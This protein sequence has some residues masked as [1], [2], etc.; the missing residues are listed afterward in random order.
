V[1]IN[2]LISLLFSAALL[3]SQQAT[4]ESFLARASDLEKHEDF[5]GAEKVYAEAVAGFPGQSEVLKRLG[6]VYQTELKFPESIEVLQKVLAANSQYPEANFYLGLSYFGLNDFEKALTGFNA[7]LK[8]NPKYRRARYY[9]A[10]ALQALDRKLEAVQYLDELVRDDPGDIKV[11]YQLARLYRSMA[12]HALKQIADV[13]ADSVLIHALKAESYSEDE[14]YADALKEYKE[15]VKKDSNFPGVHFG[16]GEVYH[17][18][19]D[20]VLSEVELK[21]ALRE[22]P[23]H[24]AAN[25]YLADIL[26]KEQK[27]S[28]A[29]PLFQRA[30]AGDPKMVLAQFQLGKCY[31]VLGDTEH[32]LLAFLKTAELN[33][34][35]KEAHY[36][37]AQIYAQRK[38]DTQRNYHMAI[39]EKLSKEEKDKSLKITER[40]LE[41]ERR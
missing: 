7:E 28:E 29:L 21:E 32:A 26:L 41:E 25:Y 24:P 30:V 19:S 13:D 4:L 6:I 1:L 12:L 36:R 39:F 10:M 38:D 22:D 14:K 5:A 31:L 16:L 40:A 23:N 18:T 35:F 17:R 2:L 34:S 3:H 15:V 11:W 20:T 37:L 8:G 27:P 33:P 9:G